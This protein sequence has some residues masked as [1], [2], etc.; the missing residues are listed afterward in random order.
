MVITDITNKEENRFLKLQ[1][2]GMLPS[3]ALL[4]I[5]TERLTGAPDDSI[6]GDNWFK[7]GLGAIGASIVVLYLYSRTKTTTQSASLNIFK[8]YDIK[9][10]DTE[11]LGK[12]IEKG[13]L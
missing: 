5:E 10:I 7:I 11:A 2:Q 1:E 9:D 8:L 12:C 6:I 13:L 3:A 4:K